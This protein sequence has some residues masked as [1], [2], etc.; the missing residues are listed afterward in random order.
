MPTATAP[1]PLVARRAAELRDELNHHAHRYYTLDAP[2]IADAEYDKLFQELQAIEAAHPALLTADSPTQRVIGRVLQGFM[3]VRH[4]VAMLSIETVTKTK[5]ESAAEANSANRGEASVESD[6]APDGARRFDARV[7]NAL[8]YDEDAPPIEYGAELKFD[9]LAINLRYEGG[10]L[11][12]AATRGDGEVGEDVTQNI[13]TIGEIPLRLR[14]CGAPVLEAV[15]Y[16]H[17]TLPTNRE[18]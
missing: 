7:R 15:S 17:L 12:Q 9:G 8:G 4:A 16:T 2:Q 10:V 11:V 14:G 3:P 1:E 18:V 6:T 13:R 5:A